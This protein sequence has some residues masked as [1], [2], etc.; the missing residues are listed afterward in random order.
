MLAK[1]CVKKLYLCKEMHIEFIKKHI[2][3]DDELVYE[4]NVVL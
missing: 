3:Y 1:F 4:G 2:I